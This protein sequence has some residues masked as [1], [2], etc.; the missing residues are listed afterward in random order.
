MCELRRVFIDWKVP[1][2]YRKV[3]PIFCNKNGK[4]IYVP[5]Y[6]K[7][8]IDNHK[9]KFIIKFT[10]TKEIKNAGNK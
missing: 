1:T 9:S 5:R 8:F 3:W 7:T 6:R 4:V 10:N 2:K